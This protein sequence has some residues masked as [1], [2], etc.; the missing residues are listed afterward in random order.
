MDSC[1]E[2]SA[3]TVRRQEGFSNLSRSQYPPFHASFLFPRI[4][5]APHLNRP[6]HGSPS[7]TRDFERT[8]ARSLGVRIENRP[9]VPSRVRAESLTNPRDSGD[10]DP[11]GPEH[12]FSR[13]AVCPT[14]PRRHQQSL[15]CSAPR[16]FR[17]CRS[18]RYFPSE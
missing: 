18:R 14:P 9:A 5:P 4:F 10:R 15:Q 16:R 12:R 13:I 8:T 11:G 2:L 1:L 3:E 7:T 6:V 17:H